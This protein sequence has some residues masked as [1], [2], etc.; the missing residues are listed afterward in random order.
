[1]AT[2][3]TS[4]NRKHSTANGHHTMERKQTRLFAAILLLATSPFTLP[5]S[6]AD[7]TLWYRQPASND[8]HLEE[9]LPLGNGRMGCMVSGGI[10]RE[11]IQF[12]EQSLW[13]GDNNWDGDYECGDHGFG[14]YR[15]FGDLVIAWNARRGRSRGRLPQWPR[16]GRWQGD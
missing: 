11:R 9:S 2:W 1:M 10:A 4:R 16:P 5:G 7:V 8:K 15:N 13:S 6:A 3:I 14:A 12:N